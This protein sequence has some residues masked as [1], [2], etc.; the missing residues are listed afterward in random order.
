M[1]QALLEE[2]RLG[3]YGQMLSALGCNSDRLQL[4]VERQ[5]DTVGKDGFRIRTH[6][7]PV[8]CSV[9][10]LGTESRLFKASEWP[11]VLYQA[12]RP[13]RTEGRDQ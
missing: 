4:S 13:L 5:D 11:P 7:S 9:T 12:N 10:G 8:P 2:F 6:P 1:G 3:I